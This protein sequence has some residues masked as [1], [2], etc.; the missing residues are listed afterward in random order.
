MSR[1]KVFM[2]LLF[3]GLCAGPLRAAG[4][5]NS[6]EPTVDDLAGATRNASPPGPILDRS[7]ADTVFAT[8]P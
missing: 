2:K 6:A 4:T 7:R 5:S 1:I 3:I 8:L